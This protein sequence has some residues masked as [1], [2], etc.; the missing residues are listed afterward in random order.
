[1]PEDERLWSIRSLIS[2][3]ARSPSLRHIRDPFFIAKLAKDI[4]RA[5]DRGTSPW[6]KWNNQREIL[7]TAAATTWIPTEDLRDH[8]N[9]LAGPKLTATDV[10]QRLRTIQEDSF[11]SDLLP[12]DEL[13]DSCLEL[14]QRER[15]VGTEMTAIIYALQEYVEGQREQ[16]QIEQEQRWRETQEKEREAA[17]QRLLSGADCK[18]TALR[19]ASELYSRINGRLYRI[20]QGADKRWVLTRVKSVSDEDGDVLGTYKGRGDAT[21]ALKEIAYRPEM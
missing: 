9:T 13:R 17:R 8:F 10:S 20:N 2:D 18:W 15:A 5:V 1:M 19:K 14:Y 21:K 16:I 6:Q 11:G 7:V 12:D 3:Y 4:L